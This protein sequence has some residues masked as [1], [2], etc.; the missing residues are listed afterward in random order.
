MTSQY[1]SVFLLECCSIEIIYIVPGCL[2]SKPVQKVEDSVL[3]IIHSLSGRDTVVS[4]YSVNAHTVVLKLV[5][6]KITK[7]YSQ[8]CAVAFC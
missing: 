4:T 7:H 6:Q 5:Y 3:E 2:G 1:S 8:Y